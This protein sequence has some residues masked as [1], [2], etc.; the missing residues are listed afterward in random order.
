MRQLLCCLVFCIAGISFAHSPPLWGQEHVPDVTQAEIL[1]NA[2]APNIQ[3]GPI[4]LTP[5]DEA[6]QLYRMGQFGEAIKRYNAL[7]ESEN[8]NAIAYAGLARAY[9]KLKKPIDAFLV[10]TKA[11]E[12]DPSLGTAHS[13]LGEVYFRQGKLNEAQV[14]FLTA[15]K[16]NRVDAR[17]YLGLARLY[18]AT[19]NLK[20][21]KVAIDQ[22]RAFDATDP[23]IYAA[24]IETRPSSEQEKALEDNIASQSNYYSRVEKASFKQRLTLIK[25]QVEHPERTCGVVSRSESTEMKL[26]PI[27]PKNGF[28]GLEVHVNDVGSR[29]VLSTASSGIVING[30]IAKE[31][32]VQQVARAD[33]DALGEENPPEVY[34]GF[35]RSIRIDKLEFQNC[36]VTVVEKTSPGSFYDQFEGL[37]A[38][39]F[40]STY[41]VDVNML[42]AK[43][44][45]QPLPTR[46]AAKD[47]DSVMD[48]GDSDAR[49]FHDRYTAPEM[50]AWQQMYR[51]GSAIVIPARVNDSPPEL[52]EVAASS[53]YN[54]LALELAREWA[55]LKSGKASAHLEGINGKVSGESSGQVKLEFGDLHFDA[56]N[57]I[58]FDDTRSSDSA[59]TKIS[60]YLGF[61]ILRNLHII[62][63][64]RDGL[65]HLDNDQKL[66]MALRR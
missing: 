35:A 31:A 36:Y 43:L 2:P 52:F 64:Y 30:D 7:I 38:A 53:K 57:V 62:I 27:G 33:M 34:I 44:K 28:M 59:E 50:V 13:A 46:P 15:L 24:W 47:Q 66:A 14:E 10:A 25:D 48:S 17:S 8:D 6:Q 4:A 26:T 65:I 41:L 23:D 12:L 51:F 22:A 9:L 5:I 18:Q 42:R 63:D 40:F 19:Y 3:E 45:L 29:L 32:G 1:P 16:L 20:K 11:V 56:I 55:S 54:V 60:G 37:V 39:G 21:A 49:N 61:D 58:S